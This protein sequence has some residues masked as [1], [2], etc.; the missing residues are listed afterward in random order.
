MRT[1]TLSPN[2]ALALHG[3]WA[4]LLLAFVV[5]ALYFGHTVF[6]P[7]ALAALITFLLSRLVSR[8]EKWIGRV[9]SVLLCVLIAF[10]IVG[11][12]SWIVGRQVVE[13][14]GNLPR[15][16]ANI[17]RKVHSLRLPAAGTLARLTSSVDAL[18]KEV[19]N[20]TP[21]PVP[22]EQATDLPS[23]K[24]GASPIPVKI[25]EGRNAIPQLVQENIAAVLSPIGRA[26]LVFLLV[27]FMLLKREDLRWRMVRLIGQ[28][29]ISATTRAMEDAASRVSR[30]LSMQFLVNACYGICV[31]L[32]LYFIGIP[33]AV[34]WGLL[35]GVLRFIPYV[36]PWAG[37]ALP[38]ILSFAISDNWIS[39]VLT[40]ALFILLEVTISNFVE[41]WLYG[42]STGVSPIALILSA[43]FW[44][45]LWGPSSE[46]AAA[47]EEQSGKHGNSCD[48]HETARILRARAGAAQG[49]CGRRYGRY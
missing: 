3:I 49:N 33:N 16:Q 4:I 23:A 37:A 36:G 11:A 29:R 26:A 47:A 34:L 18:Q 31:A 10:T 19:I 1:R 22:K 13:L 2:S 43:V 41:P 40:I 28:G 6:V 15:Y 42:A 39:P 5:A 7:I 8:L 45:W 24:T 21:T 20:G 25:I 48:R 32:G 30:Y 9:A 14:A 17:T 12:V 27:I 46:S 35:A 38:V 44:T